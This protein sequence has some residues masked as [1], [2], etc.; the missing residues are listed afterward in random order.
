MLVSRRNATHAIL[1]DDSCYIVV[2]M[3]LRSAL[4]SKVPPSVCHP[5]SA[6]ISV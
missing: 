4:T 3:L 1:S 5:M 6:F 2:L